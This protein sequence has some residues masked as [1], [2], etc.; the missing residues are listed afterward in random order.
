MRSDEH[1]RTA[2][3][4]THRQSRGS[5]DSFTICA[6]LSESRRSEVQSVHGCIQRISDRRVSATYIDGYWAP[7]R[8]NPFG[9]PPK[10][11]SRQRQ[12][13][14]SFAEHAA[15]VNHS[16]NE[17]WPDRRESG[18]PRGKFK[19]DENLRSNRR[20]CGHKNGHNLLNGFEGYCYKLLILWLLR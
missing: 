4:P 17:R 13:S 2:A 18:T 5:A 20:R 16:N 8:R 11:N 10:Q 1:I 7:Y 15:C 12:I 3:I 6:S 9:I 14:A 19:F